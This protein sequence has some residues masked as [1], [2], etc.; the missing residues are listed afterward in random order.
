MY[1]EI[2]KC[3]FCQ[4]SEFDA[5]VLGLHGIIPKHYQ[6]HDRQSIVHGIV[7]CLKRR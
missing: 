1:Q 4:Q 3:A 5:A 7:L 6:D 2:Q